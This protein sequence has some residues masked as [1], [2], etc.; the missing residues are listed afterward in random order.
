M[1]TSSRRSARETTTTTKPSG[2]AT[3]WGFIERVL[4]SRN[5]RTAYLWGKPGM[6]KTFAAY[7]LGLGGALYALTVTEETAGAEI[8]GHYLP[9]GREMPWHDGPATQAMREGARLVINELSHGSADVLSM[10]HPLLENLDTARLTLPTG[11]TVRPA[12]GFQLFCTDNLPP[13]DLPEALRDRFDVI[14]EVR[15]PHPAALAQLDERL[16]GP[17][18]RSFTLEPDRRISLRGWLSVQRLL[19]EFG[20]EYAV[21]AVFGPTRGAMVLDGLLL[22]EAQN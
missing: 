3:D 20:L 22:G 6:G 9:K 1:S 11:E 2:R 12:H 19:P 17:A 15:E 4:C 13:E 8:R 10:L 16:R 14:I 21:L 5:V 7:H 18:L